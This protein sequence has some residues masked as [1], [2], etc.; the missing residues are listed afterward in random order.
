MPFART[1]FLD[2]SDFNAGQKSSFYTALFG[3]NPNNSTPLRGAL[4]KAGKYFAKKGTLSGGGA[5]TYDPVQ[6]SCQRNF[7]ILTTDGYW[8]N[9][10]ETSSYGPLGLY[11]TNVGQQ[12]GQPTARPLFDGDASILQSRTSSL[13]QSS[14]INPAQPQ[15]STSA[16]QT[17][18]LVTPAQPQQST[19]NLQ[20]WTITA[21]WRSSTSTLQVNTG[22]LQEQNRVSG[23]W[24]RVWNNVARAPGTAIRSA[25][26]SGV[27]LSMRPPLAQR[28]P[29]VRAR[30]TTPPGTA[31][32]DCQYTAWTP[33]PGVT[34]TCTAANQS[35]G[36]TN[37]TRLTATQCN[38]LPPITGTPANVTSCMASSTVGCGYT[39]W[40]TPVNVA[41][42]TNV[43]QDNSSPH[44]VGTAVQCSTV[45]AVWGPWTNVATGGTCST[46]STTECQ[47]T[48]WSTPVNSASCTAVNQSTSNPYNVVNAV[49][50][51][52]IPAVTGPWANVASCSASAS[53]ACQYTA[54][55]AWGNVNSCT[56]L[57]QSN[58]PNYTVG[59][60]TQCQSSGFAGSSDSL[61]D[62]AMYYYEHD[63]R[64][65]ALNNCTATVNGNPIDV[66]RNNLS[67]SG[68]DNVNWQ[69]M[70]TYTLGMGVS[71]TLRYRPD[72]LT[73]DTGTYR[74]LIQGTTDW[75]VPVENTETA[76]D[77]LWHA[78]V[79]GRGR[80][81]S[82]GDPVSLAASLSNALQSIEAQMAS[83]S[84][85]A[86][87][88]LQPVA[89]DN[90]VFIAKYKSVFW[91]G[92]LVARDIDP[93]T[94]VIA[95]PRW[96]AAQKLQAKVDAG[97]PRT[98]YYGKRNAGTNTGAF[99]PF[100][101]AQL[102]ADGLNGYFDSACSKV[103]ALSQC[104]TLIANQTT[105]NAAYAAGVTPATQAAKDAADA[106]LAAANS[107]ANMIDYLRG[108][109][110]SVY[111]TRTTGDIDIGGGILGD[112]IGGAPVYVRKPSFNYVE[113]NYA[114]FVAA[115]DATNPNPP[116]TVPETLRGRRGVVYAGSNDGMLHA[117]DGVSGEELWAYIPSM[118]MD[119][120]YR[121]ADTDYAN[122][123]EY[124]VNAAPVIGDIYI[125]PVAPAT[126][127]TWKTI[128]VGGLGAGGRGYY[129]LDITN[130]DS[131]SLLWEFSNDALGGNS[132]LGQ[133]FGNPVITKRADG[134]WVV[135]F[136]SGYN[137]V[138][139]TGDVTPGDGTVAGDGNGHLFLIDANTGQRLLD[140][141]TF[142]AI[143]VPAG[144][145]TTPSGLSKLNAW[146]D[147]DIDNTA[148]RFYAGDLLGNLWRFDTDGL[149]A[150]TNAALRL[151]YFA[152]GGVP[153]PITTQPSLAQVNYNGSQ[154]AVAYVGTGRYLGT[155]DLGNTALQSVYAIKD[156]LTN[157][158]L[159]DAHASSSVVA[160]TLSLSDPTDEFS[161]RNV[162]SQP[163]NWSTGN[164]W[165]VDLTVATLP[166]PGERVNV[167]MQLLNNTLA[168]AT[169]IPGTDVCK[170]GGSSYYYEFDIGTG[171]KPSTLD[172]AY[173]GQWL[174]DSMVVGL[175]WVTLQVS[176][177]SPGSGRT[178]TIAV[179]SKSN[180]RTD[181]V[182]PADP[183]PSVGRRTSWRE[184]VN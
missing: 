86:A 36:P 163:V 124:F 50:C 90:T 61:A 91:N 149:V 70:T 40:S 93:Q 6:Y 150:P 115:I 64:T 1:G 60:A 184:L 28:S 26:T 2:V 16:L 143:G 137:N 33:V 7:A 127:G 85:A 132:N 92:D 20:Q 158:P 68:S 65:P 153:Q 173:V 142:T 83:G 157:A 122:R 44:T 169:N 80:Y 121:L 108:G 63:L 9:N 27:D 17:R 162:T 77:D 76:V 113:N 104:A 168:V 73:A 59:T 103:V 110:N 100:T 8:N 131:P 152:A 34:T 46:S 101:Y 15:T 118:V 71:G 178:V 102:T 129:A 165:R 125:A 177:G 41:S 119:R 146:V 164:G 23:N 84:G 5:Q 69:H 74:D 39:A 35:T 140:I 52:T 130:P 32:R 154:F 148:K 94:G 145:A 155:T 31:R 89:G 51:N 25:A 37:Y 96:S 128:I 147:A 111:R 55:T 156:P 123:H 180:P 181:D 172:T 24:S 133:S 22:Q 53:V 167:D 106:A 78:A 136:T 171:S 134:T 138:T 72:Y 107:G 87:S 45:P 170:S 179:D 166:T 95:P 58:G 116:A 14:I 97:T 161:P 160:Q 3:A 175:S 67:P 66:C 105:A 43:N 139:Y 12:D 79:D 42:C 98:L 151:A 82:A 126:V 49:Q 183:P 182:P 112:I 56:A 10:D 30:E 47:Y 114:G 159:G 117:F 21:Q 29:R 99:R 144:T 120:M 88:T 176:G 81:F 62:V 18:A 48:P 135:A 109:S 174:G 11:G 4:S 13:Q 141:P 38:A 54:W 57:A 75:P 19:S